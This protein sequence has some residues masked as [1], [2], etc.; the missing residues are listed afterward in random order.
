[1]RSSSIKKQPQS[2]ISMLRLALVLVGIIAGCYVSINAAIAE[3]FKTTN[4]SRAASVWPKNGFALS[5]V[6]DEK[7]N[8]AAAAAADA[9]KSDFIVGNS[10]KL[11]GIGNLALQSFEA[12]PLNASALRSLAFAA[13]AKGNS[14]RAK[15]LMADAI[16]FSRRDTAANNWQ[17]QQALKAQDLPVSMQLVDRILREDDSLYLSYLPALIAGVSQPEGMNAIL[18]LLLKRP[19]WEDQFWSMATSQPKIPPELAVLRQNLYA[20]RRQKL[21]MTPFLDADV[22]LIQNLISS[23]QFD[24]AK[25]LHDFLSGQDSPNTKLK[26]GGKPPTGFAQYGSPFDWQLESKNEVQAYFNDSGGGLTLEVGSNSIGVFARKLV[27][28]ATGR[29]NVKISAK[30]EPG[31]ELFGRFRCLEIDKQLPVVNL[32]LNNDYASLEKM[33]P[34]DCSWFMLEIL[35]QSKLEGTTTLDISEIE[36]SSN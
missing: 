28:S 23:N 25:S 15:K 34:T 36:V 7:L 27:K 22:Y 4:P 12:E 11:Q 14:L 32:A 8:E 6:A 20:K 9:G 24:A 13:E 17:L 35:A 19:L 3:S 10:V 1:M 2:S 5:A 33:K 18:P 29:F 26:S 21:P 16:K 31:I 30:P